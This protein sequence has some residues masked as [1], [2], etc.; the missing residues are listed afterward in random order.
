MFRTC[1]GPVR[2]CSEHHFVWNMVSSS[3]HPIVDEPSNG[4]KRSTRSDLKK[5]AEKGNSGEGSAAKKKDGTGESDSSKKKDG[6]GGSDA[7]S[8]GAKDAKKSKKASKGKKA[9]GNDEKGKGV[10]SGEGK[11]GGAKQRRHRKEL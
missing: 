5:A 7:K 9:L 10:D 6:G 8:K 11:G 3:P 1:S 2:N 4:N